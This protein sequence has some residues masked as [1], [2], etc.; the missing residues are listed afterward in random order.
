MYLVI[1]LT[2]MY[3]SYIF[4]CFSGFLTHSAQNSWNFLSVDSDKSISCYDNKVTFEPH[5]RMGLVARRTNHVIRG[6]E[7]SVLPPTPPQGRG[8]GLDFESIASGHQFNQS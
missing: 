4:G 8:E 7:L 5:L 1:Q 2:K 3:F 6:L